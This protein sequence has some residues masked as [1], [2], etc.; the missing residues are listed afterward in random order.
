M[1]PSFRLVTARLLIGLV[2]FFNVEC[3]L[4]F[5]I[6]P[7]NFVSSFEL[8]GISGRAMVQALGLLFIMWNVPY[9]VA[10]TQP[11]RQR[12]SHVQ[13]IVM[14]AIGFMGETWILLSLAPGHD[15]LRSTAMRFI[16]FD[17][18]GLLALL[19]AFLLLKSQRTIPTQD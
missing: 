13:A 11:V 2:L 19:G 9:A 1:K 18:L 4:V 6:S 7:D 17:S 5:L 10:F 16:T 3:G 12:V 14:Q 8:N 15:L